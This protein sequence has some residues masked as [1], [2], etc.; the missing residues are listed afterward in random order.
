M[1]DLKKSIINR[2]FGLVI[3]V[4]VL[5]VTIS[6][7]ISIDSAFK[8]FSKET[9]QTLFREARLLS[10]LLPDSISIEVVDSILTHYHF[11]PKIRFTFIDK[12]GRVMVDTDENPAM[13]D[14]HAGRPEIITAFSEGEGSTIRFSA[15]LKEHLVY[16]ALRVSDS[17]VIR[18]SKPVSSVLDFKNK[19]VREVI[20][21]MF[22]LIIV[23]VI[24]TVLSKS[25]IVKKI[26][27]IS[28]TAKQISKGDFSVRLEESGNSEFNQLEKAVNQMAGEIE[29]SF[30]TLKAQEDE[31]SL[32]LDSLRDGIILIK[33][34]NITAMNNSAER[35]LKIK[36]E[37]IIGNDALSTIRTPEIIGLIEKQSGKPVEFDLDDTRVEAA[38]F[39]SLRGDSLIIVVR[40]IT[41]QFRIRKIK[42]DF[43]ANV[44]HELK[45][46]LTLIKGYTETLKSESLDDEQKKYIDITERHTNRMIAIVEDLLTLT[47]VESSAVPLTTF[48]YLPDMID[49]IVPMFSKIA[50]KAKVTISIDFAE[51]I[52]EIQ[53]DPSLIEIAISNLIDNAVKYNKE[54]GE[55]KIECY[56]VG[57]GVAVA[58]EDTGIGIPFAETD[59]V[60]E[61]FYT[62]DKAHSHKL[63]GTGLGLS[64]VKNIVNL[65]DGVVRVDTLKTE[66]CRFEMVFPIKPIS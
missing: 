61:R 40:D 30:A 22:G 12:T 3:F 56:R 37:N 55:V 17:L 7:F 53:G 31:M 44:S 29:S 52:P 24:I 16:S 38:A 26:S 49:I 34:G 48:I 50:Q 11:D 15:T 59:K 36:C 6:V 5:A 43:V 1:L 33:N 39:P 35:V 10:E 60:F 8:L 58:V 14:N 42:A 13:M 51:D 62:V 21:L 9:Q 18:A 64:I 4:M 32:I 41:E 25:A 2:Y 66:G 45:T 54:G 63:G 20:P 57:E 47:K 28:K 23:G 27:E 19:H 65:H 46:P